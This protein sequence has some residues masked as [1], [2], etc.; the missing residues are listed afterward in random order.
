MRFH[1]TFTRNK[2]GGA[3]P[4]LL[5]GDAVPT[6]KPDHS[7]DNVYSGKLFTSQDCPIYRI[8]LGYRAPSG[9][10]ALDA[11]VYVWDELSQAWWLL[12]GSGAGILIPGK[13]A[14]V[15]FPT[16]GDRIIKPS[17]ND[18][19][20]YGSGYDVFVRVTDPGAAPDGAHLFY[21]YGAANQKGT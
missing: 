16:P 19:V 20:Q 2:G 12:P 21:V 14:S 10:L 17:S 6:A 3:L 13:L 4:P 8:V 9:T 11:E 15:D 5:G 7:A 18:V 1:Q